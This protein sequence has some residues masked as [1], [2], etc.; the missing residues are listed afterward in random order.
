MHDSPH[1][2][3]SRVARNPTP[4]SVRVQLPLDLSELSTP[5]PD[6]A[7]VS[8]RAEDYAAAH[9][10]SA[11]LVVEVADSTVLQER[12]TKGPITRPPAWAS[13]GW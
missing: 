7:V 11:L 10:T 2:R 4:V 12:M 9:P 5:E 3:G 8:G 13:I 6:L 1:N